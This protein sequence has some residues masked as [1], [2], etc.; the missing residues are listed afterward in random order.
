MSSVG[1]S[2]PLRVQ[3]EH[4]PHAYGLS[5]IYASRL[6]A[7]FTLSSSSST[8]GNTGVSTAPFGAVHFTGGLSECHAAAHPLL[9]VSDPADRLR[10]MCHRHGSVRL[11][12]VLPWRFVAAVR[13][14]GFSFKFPF[15]CLIFDS[16]KH[17][18]T[19]NQ[20]YEDTQCPIHLISHEKISLTKKV[21]L[22]HWTQ[23]A[24]VF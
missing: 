23:R 3:R 6:Y 19:Y 17:K 24:K 12:G 14:S 22:D 4:H 21:A 20:E 7:A 1:L 9:V 10:G 2:V 8:F 13:R 5:L 15:L 11:Q 18:N 16:H